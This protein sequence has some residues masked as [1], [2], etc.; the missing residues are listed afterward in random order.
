MIA[1]PARDDS[2]AE[3]PLGDAPASRGQ[4]VQRTGDGVAHQQSQ[5]DTEADER[6]HHGDRQSVTP[7]PDPV[8]MR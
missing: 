3:V 5:H 2:F 6:D 1:R 7:V 4:P 8:E